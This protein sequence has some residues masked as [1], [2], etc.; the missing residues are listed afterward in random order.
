MSAIKGPDIVKDS[1]ILKLDAANVRS[2]RGEPVINLYSIAAND[3][4]NN[5]I[6]GMPMGGTATGVYQS[7]FDIGKWNNNTIFKVTISAG[8]LASFSSFRFCVPS[9]FDTTYGTTRRLSAKIKMIKGQI[10][11]LSVHN[12]GGNS[13]HNSSIF[14]QIEPQNTP[15]DV[16]DKSGWFQ[17][18]TD[19]SGSYPFGQC[20]G[21]GIVTSD[22][23]FLVTEMMLYPSSTLSFFTPTTRGT[24]VST[25]GG[26]A[27]LTGN[28]NHGELINGPTFNNDSSGSINFDGID[29]TINFSNDL[30][31]NFTYECWV[32]HNV[33][34]GF[35]FLGQGTTSTRAGLHIWFS[36]ATNLR[37]GMFSNDTDATSLTTS[38][39][40]WYHYVFTYNHSTFVKTIHRNG[41]Q[42]ATTPIQTQTSY[43]GTGTVRI[44]ATY[45][46]GGAYANG[47]FSNVKLYDKILSSQEIQRNYNALKGR[48]AL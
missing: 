18:D 38:T 25:G 26:W 29:D 28:N 3:S 31:K 45:S 8:T 42:L 46:S 41:V 43:I 21:I 35:S 40:V 37:F 24:T 32:K 5:E 11:G 27:D 34:N 22:I 47:L 16:I 6:W 13:S 19:V 4:A 17:L 30:R 1:L 44:G 36:A 39:G 48:Y 14:T 15:F 12:G 23:E 9:T 10:S 20:V 33:V 7:F 2:F